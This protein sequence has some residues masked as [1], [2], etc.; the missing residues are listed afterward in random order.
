MENRTLKK[1]KN[2]KKGKNSSKKSRNQGIERGF[3]I[4]HKDVKHSKKRQHRS[5]DGDE[6]PETKKQCKTTNKNHVLLNKEAS[7]PCELPA[8]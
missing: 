3:T 8:A 2:I 4:K 5:A 7:K 1:R 6:G